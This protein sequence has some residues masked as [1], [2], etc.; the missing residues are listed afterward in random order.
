MYCKS[1]YHLILFIFAL[2]S[3]SSIIEGRFLWDLSSYCIEYCS[4]VSGQISPI[5]VCSCHRI[6]SYHRRMDLDQLQ[7]PFK[8]NSNHQQTNEN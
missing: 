4:R 6:T 8:H 2:Y 3:M 7:I 1:S 5:G